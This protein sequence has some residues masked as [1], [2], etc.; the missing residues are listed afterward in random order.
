MAAQ[1][2]V[3]VGGNGA[4]MSAASKAKRRAPHLEIEVLEA[5]PYISY[6]VC[7][8]PSLLE[9]K[10]GDPNDLLVLTPEKA[11]ERGINIRTGC[12]VISFNAYTKEVVYTTEKGGRD[13]THYDR[14]LIA[15][16][17]N[18]KNPFKGREL[19]GVH[20]IRHF[21]DGLRAV[22]TFAKA[23]KVAIIGAG[24][25]GLEMAASLKSQG[26]DVHLMTRGKRLL[27]S[28]DPDITD[29][30]TEWMESAGIKVTLEAGVKGFAE[31]KKEGQLG[32]VEAKKDVTADAAL[33]AVGVEASTHFAVKSSVTTDKDSFILVDDNMHTNFHDVWAAGDCVAARH[34]VT[35]RPTP[36]PLALAANRMGRVAGDNIAASLDKI[37]AGSMSFPGVL[38]TTVTYLFG[39]AFAQTG[40][41]EHTAKVEGIDAVAALV[42]SKDKAA[43][44]PTS[45]DMAVK[46]LAERGSGK[47]LGVQMA[48]PAESALRINAAAVALQLGAKV[49]KL[50]DI[51]T[52]YSPHFSPVYDPLTVAA[53]ECA[54]L[55][56]S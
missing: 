48:C 27:T 2:L 26:T 29:G 21:D 55:V 37:P 30:L 14:L 12:R 38:G 17:T 50:A 47:L 7:G 40:I 4:G 22:Q 36:M 8:I 34:M 18:A 16:G 33:V 44:M 45:A 32:A 3:V 28:M 42:E 10:V 31:G 52:A 11:G 53:T 1:R 54:K 39:L 9:G 5:S 13:S 6:S 23:K 41:T 51:E 46:V 20:S 56:K 24:F 35:G 25:V 49:H 19:A 43:Y 15:T